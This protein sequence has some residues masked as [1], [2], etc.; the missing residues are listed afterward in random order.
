MAAPSAKPTTSTTASAH[1]V[2]T[3][4]A[5]PPI[6]PP[7]PTMIPTAPQAPPEGLDDGVKVPSTSK[8]D[9]GGTQADGPRGPNDPVTYTNKDGTTITVTP[10]VIKPYAVDLDQLASENYEKVYDLENSIQ[11]PLGDG[12]DEMTKALDSWLPDAERSL[13]ESTMN[14]VG[15]VADFGQAIAMMAKTADD[16]ENEAQDTVTALHGNLP[17]D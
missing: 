16:A 14:L 5:P 9:P 15:G 2:A 1:P 17:S 3:P 12:G 13:V 11:G 7:T 4:E 8:P 6:V 10:S